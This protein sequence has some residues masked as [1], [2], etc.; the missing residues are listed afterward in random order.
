MACAGGGGCG[1]GGGGRK[2]EGVV[3]CEHREGSAT[4]GPCPLSTA[5]LRRSLWE[6]V[7]AREPGFRAC[8]R[9]PI[10]SPA[11]AHAQP[12]GAQPRAARPAAAARARAAGAARR[13]RARGGIQAQYAPSMYFGLWSR[14]GG[15]SSRGA[16]AGAREARGRPGHADAGHDPPRLAARL[17]AVRRRRPRGAPALGCARVEGARRDGDGRGRPHARAALAGGALPRK[18]VEALIGKPAARGIH[19]WLDL[20]RVPPSGTWERRRADLFGAAAD[21]SPGPADP[22]ER[23]GP[24][25]PPLSGGVRAR[26]AQGRR[27]ASPA[28]SLTTLKPVLERRHRALPRRGRRRAARRRRRAAARPGHAR[29]AAAAADLGRDAARPRPPHRPAARALPPADL[30]HQEPAVVADLPRRRRGRRHLGK[31]D[32]DGFSA[33]PFERV[34]PQAMREVRAEGERLAAA[35]G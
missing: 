28:C 13:A 1:P 26:L 10:E 15:T 7:R 29:A 4:A 22:D 19:L 24:P 21:W 27:R 5:G 34:A 2:R 30:P 9:N 25:R 17:L 14:H 20:V 31:L 6:S 23:H 35:F 8:R 3:G 18:E 12:A 16:D 32:G 33:E 11:R